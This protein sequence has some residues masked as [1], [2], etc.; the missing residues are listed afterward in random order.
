MP[1]F[2]FCPNPKCRL[3][4][5]APSSAWFTPFGFYPT[6]TFGLVRRFR[7][8]TCRRTF[9]SQTFSVDY[10]A[11]R[12]VNY[13][14]LLDRHASSAS[15]RALSRTLRLSCGTIQNRLDRLARQGI[16]LHAQVRRFA[17][18]K[19][20]VC[21]D[22]L[23]S[24]DVSQFFPNEITLSITS[25]SRFVLDVSHATRRRSGT[26]TNDQ[27]S[28]A[29]ELYPRVSL[30]WG[31]ISRTFRDILDGLAEDR[32][33]RGGFPL[34]LITD[35]KKEYQHVL[36][37][38]PLFRNQDESHR[39]AHLRVP[40]YLPRTYANPL[41]AS[42]YLDREIRKDQANHHRET[43]CYSRNVSN[44]MSRLMCYLVHHNYRKRYRIGGKVTE[45]R[46]HGE[47]AGIPRPRIDQG[48]L[49]MFRLRAFLTRIR[50]TESQKRI[51]KK[52]YPTPLKNGPE[53]LPAYATA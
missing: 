50:L 12:R 31:A 16:A 13:P 27:Q 40:S 19:E 24:F 47:V 45:I 6:R 41:F 32:A 5:V 48:L 3:H 15:L 11:K 36:Y 43:V 39:V 35:E 37:R 20:A 1:S 7:C 22:G 42:N 8:R 28:R 53:Y 21:V 17:D 2:P 34:V 46:V 4:L 23:V 51:W 14:D 49:D 25:D 52:E 33:E 30:E 44:G 10:F 38:H 26:M 29:S 18:P 9:S